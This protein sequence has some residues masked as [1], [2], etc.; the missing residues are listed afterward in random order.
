VREVLGASSYREAAARAAR[1]IA[2]E[3]SRDNAADVLEELAGASRSDGAL[4][5]AGERLRDHPR[6]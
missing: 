6:N 2:A 3:Q 4:V 1:T 5:D